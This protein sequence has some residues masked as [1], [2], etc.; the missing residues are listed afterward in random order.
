MTWSKHQ[1][2]Y[3]FK[4]LHSSRQ[5]FNICRKYLMHADWQIYGREKPVLCLLLPMLNFQFTL[6]LPL[7]LSH[8]YFVT[9][10]AFCQTGS[11]L[12]SKCLTIMVW[13]S[14]EEIYVL[15]LT[16]CSCKIISMSSSFQNLTVMLQ[17]TISGYFGKP[18]Q[19]VIAD[20]EWYKVKLSLL[21]FLSFPD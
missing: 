5:F 11:L 18:W 15:G 12:I 21:G 7:C 2:A 20:E 4:D 13:C 6:Y 17:M 3:A 16:K 14:S 8:L 9:M 19:F 10:D 1:C